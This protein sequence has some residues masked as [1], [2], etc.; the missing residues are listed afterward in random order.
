MHDSKI[1]NMI[2]DESFNTTKNFSKLKL[3]AKI[4]PLFSMLI[5]A[6][7]LSQLLT[8]FSKDFWILLYSYNW[9]H[10]LANLT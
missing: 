5:L 2:I 9:C 10:N 4:E 6:L 1:G 7:V 3:V 8:L